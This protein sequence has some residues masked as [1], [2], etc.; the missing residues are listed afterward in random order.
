[1][2]SVRESRL[3]ILCLVLTAM[4]AV[5]ACSDAV[6]P[7]PQVTL[8][9]IAGRYQLEKYDGSALPTNGPVICFLVG[10]GRPY[11]ITEGYAEIGKPGPSN[12]TSSITSRDTAPPFAEYTAIRSGS[13]EVDYF[14]RLTF[15]DDGLDLVVQWREGAIKGDVLSVSAFGTYTF[16]RTA[17][18]SLGVQQLE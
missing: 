11:L 17:A 13:L 8:E 6:A 16:R 7:A 2:N 15:H 18:P 14:G 9:S 10:C 3:P 4:T 12:W 5:S 1:M